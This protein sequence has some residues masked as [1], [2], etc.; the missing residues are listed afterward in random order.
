MEAVLLQLLLL[1]V[2]EEGSQVGA[3]VHLVALVAAV[4]LMV[5]VALVLQDKVMQVV[6]LLVH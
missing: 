5:V 1:V 2:V 6:I 4:D 3:L